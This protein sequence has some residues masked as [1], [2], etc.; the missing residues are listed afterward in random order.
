MAQLKLG[1]GNTADVGIG[2]YLRADKI[3]GGEIGVLLDAGTLREADFGT[4]KTKTVIEFNI[5]IDEEEYM[6]T[7]NK[8]T[9]NAL[10]EAYGDDCKKWIGKKV[11]LTKVKMNVFG[12]MK[13][14]IVGEPMEG[15]DNVIDGKKV[16]TVKI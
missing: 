4:G 5:E 15:Q 13:M 1:D 9:L 7:M 3:A 6:W 12:E 16:K 2:N 10:A 14:V 11:K 8:Q